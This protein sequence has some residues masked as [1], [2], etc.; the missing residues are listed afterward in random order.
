MGESE[1]PGPVAQLAFGGPAAYKSFLYQN[2]SHPFLDNSIAPVLYL[3][4]RQPYF[5]NEGV[6][7]FKD[8]AAEGSAPEGIWCVY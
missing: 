1:L 6:A 2:R 3:D 8:A 7:V 5:L 4:N